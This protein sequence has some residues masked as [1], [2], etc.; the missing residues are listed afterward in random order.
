M[1]LLKLVHQ[2]RYGLRML[3]VGL[4]VLAVIAACLGAGVTLS[5]QACEGYYAT[6]PMATRCICGK[7]LLVLI[8][9][10]ALSSLLMAGPYAYAAD[11]KPLWK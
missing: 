8:G 1:R 9:F 4:P 6:H 11:G 5:T 2:D 10:M 7:G 3:L